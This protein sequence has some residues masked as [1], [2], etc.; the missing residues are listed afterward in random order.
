MLM[1]LTELTV[2]PNKSRIFKTANEFSYFIEQ[3]A[4]K[5][6]EECYTI[7]LEYCEKN[8]VDYEKLVPMVND[9]L[10]SKLAV[11]FGEMGMLPKQSSLF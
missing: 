10:K 4:V 2:T 9:Q 11:E 7:I 1:P 8:D 5:R 3:E 6:R